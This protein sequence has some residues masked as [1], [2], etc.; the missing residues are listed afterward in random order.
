MGSIFA[1][2][3]APIDE[4]A[5]AVAR[6]LLL[7][8]VSNGVPPRK[9]QHVAPYGLVAAGQVRAGPFGEPALSSRLPLNRPQAMLEDEL[10][11]LLALRDPFFDG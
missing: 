10:S 9:G 4:V 5:P 8:V 1:R 7:F 2:I 11:D 6:A 3:Y